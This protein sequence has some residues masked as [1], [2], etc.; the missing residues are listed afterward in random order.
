MHGREHGGDGRAGQDCCDGVAGRQADVVAGEHVGDDDVQRDGGLLEALEAE[1]VSDEVAQTGVG[2]EVA[3]PA[4]EPQEPEQGPGGEDVIAAE[5]LPQ[6]CE[7]GDPV[8]V[9]AAGDPRTVDG[10]DGGADDEVRLDAGF[11]QC[12][13][14]ADLGG[15]ERRAPGEDERGGHAGSPTWDVIRS[16]ASAARPAGSRI[17]TW[18]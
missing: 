7:V 13:E 11:A 14:H 5:S 8:G 17:S 3:S 15:A 10:P 12:Q 1:V 4:R 18:R 6:A 16:S 2:H 9:G